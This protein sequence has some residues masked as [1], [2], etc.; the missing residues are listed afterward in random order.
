MRAIRL[1]PL[2]S[3]GAMSGLFDRAG[4]DMVEL[5]GLL[6][7]AVEEQAAMS[8]AAA[9]EAERELRQVVVQVPGADGALVG[10]EQPTLEQRGDPVNTRHDD[11]GGIAAARDRGRVV[12]V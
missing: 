2:V 9:V 11:V 5:D 8:R 12:D 4:R 1:T 10:A 6:E 7:Q 3:I